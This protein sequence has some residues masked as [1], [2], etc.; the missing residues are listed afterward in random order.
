MKRSLVSAPTRA[1]LKERGITEYPMCPGCR[2]EMHPGRI[3]KAKVCPT[4]RKM[5]CA[6]CWNP[7]S[8]SCMDCTPPEQ[9]GELCPD[10]LP[11]TPDLEIEL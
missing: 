8:D 1:A 9:R 3:L 4:C 7:Y 5:T 11:N 2:V 10:G 6:D